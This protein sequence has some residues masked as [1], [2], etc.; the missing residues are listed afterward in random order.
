[1]WLVSYEMQQWF[2][3]DVGRNRPP[4]ELQQQLSCDVSRGWGG[5]SSSSRNIYSWRLLLRFTPFGSRPV[6]VNFD[7][8]QKFF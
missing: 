6:R 1:M 4:A 5:S 3:E 2:D 7:P 8:D